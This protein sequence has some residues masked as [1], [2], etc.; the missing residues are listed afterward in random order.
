V[1]KITMRMAAGTLLI[2]LALLP[3]ELAVGR[4]PSLPAACEVLAF[5]TEEDFVGRDTVI[6]DGD[7]LAIYEDASGAVQCIICARN[8]DL[9]PEAWE[10]P[11]DV[12]LDAADVISAE[13]YLVAFS[14]ELSSPRF[15][16][17]DLLATNGV[18]IPNRALTYAHGQGAVGYDLGLDAVHFVGKRED[19]ARF[20]ADLA[21]NP[22]Q[23]PS[24]LPGLLAEYS[25]DILYSTEGTWSPP[26]GAV[27]FLD[28]DLLSAR[29]G[30]IVA[31]N[32]VL[33]PGS[34][35]AGIP[36]RGVDFGLDAATTNRMGSLEHLHFSTSILFDGE[37][38]FTDGDVLLYGNGVI[39]TNRDLNWCFQP[40]AEFLGLDALHMALE[41]TD[42]EIHGLK[43]H[44]LDA[45][46]VLDP[47][48]PGLGQWEIHLDGQ[49]GSGNPVSD[50]AWTGPTG[51]YS[52]TVP[53]GSYT[54]SEVCQD[55][56][57]AQSLPDPTDG[58]GSGR[59][60]LPVASGQIYT[61]IDFGNF[62]PGVDYPIY[63]P[64][65]LRNAGQDSL[66]AFGEGKEP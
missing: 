65:I 24:Q 49:D 27:G 52:F 3:A 54:I 16:H 39:A 55:D 59:H 15:T 9:L 23:D 57:W 47:R 2:L 60:E 58:C 21:A 10:I 28:G 45:D 48:E 11:Y 8:A 42:G 17:G 25:I 30:T 51:V 43:F 13:A 29:D 12:G 44:D 56:G 66:P 41:V 5:S 22:L 61:D 50:V 38:P 63:L 20:L 64:I 31:G 62:R 35:P 19:I 33:L 53:P 4:P 6:S 34:V 32:D 26:T 7:L 1:R 14:A 18:I 40:A 36:S 46:G 37:P